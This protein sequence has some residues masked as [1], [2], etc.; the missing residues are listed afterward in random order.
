MSQDY[1]DA[2]SIAASVRSQEVSARSAV[3]A[4]LARIA[5]QN[6]SLNCFTSVIAEQALADAEA[7]DQAIAQ[8]KD[9]GL[10]AGVPFGVKDLFD[11]AGLTTLAGSKINAECR[12]QHGMPHW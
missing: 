3:T 6:P 12:L 5:N 2:S 9:P 4:A 7:V 1:P 10:L 11:I 8:G